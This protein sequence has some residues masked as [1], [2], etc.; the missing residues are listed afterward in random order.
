[1]PTVPLHWEPM[2]GLT[3]RFSIFHVD[4]YHSKI[5]AAEADYVFKIPRGA[6]RGADFYDFD[7]NFDFDNFPSSSLASSKRMARVTTN[8]H[9]APP[10][11]L[12]K[13][14]TAPLV[15]SKSFEKKDFYDLTMTDSDDDVNMNTGDTGTPL[16]DNLFPQLCSSAGR[17]FAAS[18]SCS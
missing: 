14:R 17:R 6:F 18:R 13:H 1:M 4:S 15:L 8:S 12:K 16:L 10:P 9:I 2:T 3:T 5:T 11:P 7:S